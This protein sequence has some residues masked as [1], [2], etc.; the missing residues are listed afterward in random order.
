MIMYIHIYIIYI[1]T[2]P[3]RLHHHTTPPHAP[4]PQDGRTPVYRAAYNGHTGAVKELIS[5]GCDINLAEKV[6]QMTRLALALACLGFRVRLPLPPLA[7][8]HLQYS[9][10]LLL[11]SLIPGRSSTGKMRLHVPRRLPLSLLLH[12][13]SVTVLACISF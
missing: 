3:A 7:H 2:T 1:S 9:F 4:S 11:Q 5:G 10:R 6:K 13:L 12:C 8:L